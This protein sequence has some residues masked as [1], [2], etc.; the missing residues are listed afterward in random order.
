MTCNFMSRRQTS[1]ARNHTLELLAQKAVIATIL[2][3][4]RTP[5][6]VST[7]A[8]AGATAFSS[9]PGW[10]SV[11]AASIGAATSSAT[12]AG[13]LNVWL[14]AT[15]WF[16]SLDCGIVEM[17]KSPNDIACQGK[18]FSCCEA[19]A[20]RRCNGARW[21]SCVEGH[22]VATKK[23]LELLLSEANSR[24]S[25]LCVIACLRFVFTKTPYFLRK[26]H[27][28]VRK[29]GASRCGSLWLF[30]RRNQLVFFYYKNTTSF[31]TE[32]CKM[33]GEILLQGVMCFICHCFLSSF[34]KKVGI[35][36]F[37]VP[38]RHLQYR[39]HATYLHVLHKITRLSFKP[40][41]SFDTTL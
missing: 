22:D 35:L 15:E 29:R 34:G 4:S 20:R 25:L 33:F 40:V 5:A 32:L 36:E 3:P 27:W 30:D 39:P 21:R 2:R 16:H 28:L 1:A 17:K 24:I 10:R 18:G 19:R 12:P 26:K 9:K 37:T 8:V 6:A 23:R 11:A 38:L 31:A 13:G 14:F 41:K 7:C